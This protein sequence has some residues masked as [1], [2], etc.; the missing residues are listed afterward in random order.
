MLNL[1]DVIKGN[2]S[3]T[4]KG[5][6]VKSSSSFVFDAWASSQEENAGKLVGK[7]ISLTIENGRIYIISEAPSALWEIKCV[8][9]NLLDIEYFHDSSTKK[10]TKCRSKWTDSDRYQDRMS[11]EHAR[12]DLSI[13]VTCIVATDINSYVDVTKNRFDEWVKQTKDF[14]TALMQLREGGDVLPHNLY[15]RLFL[16]LEGDRMAGYALYS[17]WVYCLTCTRHARSPWDNAIRTLMNKDGRFKRFM[18]A[19]IEGIAMHDTTNRTC[20]A[21][22]FRDRLLC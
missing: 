20:N 10:P 18:L 16:P 13:K 9:E 2:I 19:V 7:E 6:I 15:F 12:G 8:D 5:V 1:Q 11:E 22:E 21:E 17:T 14:E 4:I 3:A